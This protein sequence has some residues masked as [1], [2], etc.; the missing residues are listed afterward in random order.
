[1]AIAADK[2]LR[3][4]RDMANLKIGLPFKTNFRIGQLFGNPMEQYIGVTPNGKHNGLDFSCPTGT[5][6]ISCT[7]GVV[8]Y[9]GADSSAGLGIYIIGQ[10]GDKSYRF[11][12]WHLQSFKVNVGDSVRSGQV[13]GISDNTGF[14]TGSHLHW[15]CK[16]VTFNGK[17]WQTDNPN[18][19]FG[20]AIDGFPFLPSVVYPSIKKGMN[21]QFVLQIQTYLNKINKSNLIIDGKYG[22]KTE[23]ATKSFQAINGLKADGIFGSLTMNKMLTYL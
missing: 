3:E 8:E 9:A 5:E 14:S 7:D 20:G 10:V 6:I 19:G 23:L 11:I 17:L 2:Y 4:N 1:M 21:G 22:I 16:P 18:N 15:G 13:I 12:Y